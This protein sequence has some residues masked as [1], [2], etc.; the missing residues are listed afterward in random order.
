MAATDGGGG[1]CLSVHV[2]AGLLADAGVAA[3]V[4]VHAVAAAPRDAAVVRGLL[5]VVV[6]VAAAAAVAGRGDVDAVDYGVDGRAD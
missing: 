6:A 1:R 4:V 5:G 2:R 3:L